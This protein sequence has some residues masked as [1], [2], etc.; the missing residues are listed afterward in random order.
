MPGVTVPVTGRAKWNA[1]PADP[2]S[3]IAFTADARPLFILGAGSVPTVVAGDCTGRRGGAPPAQGDF[4]RH[5][6]RDWGTQYSPSKAT[7][8]PHS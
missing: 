4:P 1:Q 6:P 8:P 3:S 5:P 2:N 7:T